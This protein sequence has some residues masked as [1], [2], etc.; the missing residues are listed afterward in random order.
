MW[1]GNIIDR[2]TWRTYPIEDV[3]SHDRENGRAMERLDGVE[4]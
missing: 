3:A 2:L 4:S 1:E